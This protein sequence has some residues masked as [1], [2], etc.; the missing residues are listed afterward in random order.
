[1]RTALRMGDPPAGSRAPQSAFQGSGPRGTVFQWMLASAHFLTR[2]VQAAELCLAD[3][4]ILPFL[5]QPKGARGVRSLPRLP[6]TGNT[7]E[8]IRFALWFAYPGSHS[9]FVPDASNSIR[10]RPLLGLV[11]RLGSKPAARCQASLDVL[12]SFLD[13]YPDVPDVRLV[14]YSLGRPTHTGETGM[15]KR[16]GIYE[17][18]RRFAAAQTPGNGRTLREANRTDLPPS[19][20][21]KRST[22]WPSLS[23][24]FP[25]VIYFMTR[26]GLDVQRLLCPSNDS[27]PHPGERQ[28]LIAKERILKDQQE[29][30]WSLFDFCRCYP[31]PQKRCRPKGARLA[32]NCLRGIS[33]RFGRGRRDSKG[34]MRIFHLGG[35]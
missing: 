2:P 10:I 13:R 24:A 23:L 16:R 9:R 33:D 22:G 17:S 34:D 14:R 20:Y 7:I 11:S 6:E 8:Q 5:R 25:T 15:K 31:V 18:I 19:R 35:P 30:R 4:F 12:A 32:V 21:T 27:R 26:Y 1:M 29:E 3:L 28:T